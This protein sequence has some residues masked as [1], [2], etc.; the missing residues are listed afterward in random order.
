MERQGVLGLASPTRW[1]SAHQLLMVLGVAAAVR[2]YAF[3]TTM[4]IAR[5]GTFYIEN[6]GFLQEGRLAQ[7]I[8][9]GLKPLY[10]FLV[11]IGYGATGDWEISGKL[12]SLIFGTGATLALYF[13]AR[14]FWE[15][16]IAL[17]AALIFAVHPMFV[18]YS[19]EVLSEMTYLFFFL[20]AIA[21]ASVGI[22][23]D[24]F[25]R[26][27]ALYV[28]MGIGAA[29]TR[30]EGILLVAVVILYL[31][32]R[33]DGRSSDGKRRYRL[34]VIGGA[35]LI[36]L[37]AIFA[38][39][40]L[41]AG[42]RSLSRIESGVLWTF[43]GVGAR[44]QALSNTLVQ[45]IV[46]LDGRGAVHWL[47]D[48]VWGDFLR[49]FFE[50]AH[51]LILFLAAGGLWRG[52]DDTTRSHL[53]ITFAVLLVY[54]GGV[55]FVN[56]MGPGHSMSHRYFLIPVAI[57]IPWAA[58]GLVQTSSWVDRRFAVSN[59]NRRTSPKVVAI[60][61]GMV[62]LVLLGR[63]V[64]FHRTDKLGIKRTGE[65]I[66]RLGIPDVKIVSPDP[67]IAFYAKGRH[68]DV[69]AQL[70]DPGRLVDFWKE[71]GADVAVHR[72]PPTDGD[73]RAFIAR[74][75]RHGMR[76]LDVVRPTD[77]DPQQAFFV[78]HL[79]KKSPAARGDAR[80]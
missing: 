76:L 21:A 38:A 8:T 6:A 17:L 62:L 5:D 15:K 78:F 9:R 55:F 1:P 63:S 16:G 61:T 65:W 3:A 68:V 11:W 56:L 32:L 41:L 30:P 60:C 26:W 74:A 12:V 27:G 36:L 50:A 37:A 42:P 24:R 47:R 48:E 22:H 51:P 18:Q 49:R 23:R 2:L 45:M 46:T 72:A 69:P 34:G 14:Q 52:K 80:P 77:A 40:Y 54:F 19:A 25:H 33:D 4:V 64:P 35:P 57:L 67:R 53:Q 79:E 43:E 44:I 39:V 70:T 29:L 59:P 28:P 20:V 31:G 7:V 58:R 66:G 73:Q 75:E 13:L 71:S 10:P